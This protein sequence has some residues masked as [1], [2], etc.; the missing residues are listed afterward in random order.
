[1]RKLLFHIFLSVVQVTFSVQAGPM[2]VGDLY[3]GDMR[4]AGKFMANMA[5]FGVAF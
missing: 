2:V 5:S 4:S 3:Q 1:M